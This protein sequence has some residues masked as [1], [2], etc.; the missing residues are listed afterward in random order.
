MRATR[1]RR[2]TGAVRHLAPPPST[3]QASDAPVVGQ[4][5]RQVELPVP[6][7]GVPERDRFAREHQD[8]PPS[9]TR[10]PRTA[11]TPPAIVRSLPANAVILSRVE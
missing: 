3:A 5:E 4:Q 1:A 6:P 8:L 7:V 11:T 2:L 10:S 9:M